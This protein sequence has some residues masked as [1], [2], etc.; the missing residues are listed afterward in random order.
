MIIIYRTTVTTTVYDT[1]KAQKKCPIK[2][3]AA[4]CLITKTLK[5]SEKHF[6]KHLTVEEK[7]KE[8]FSPKKQT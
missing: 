6:K 5:E 7:F 3:N 4:L 8:K 1:I 2:R